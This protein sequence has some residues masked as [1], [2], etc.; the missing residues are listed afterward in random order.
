MLTL[1]LRN[2][3]SDRMT[4]IEC[5]KVDI[6]KED[7]GH[8]VTVFS[9]DKVEEYRVSSGKEYDVG[10]IENSAGSTTQVIRTRA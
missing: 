6:V 1:K 7:G 10:Y 5:D 8:K 3:Q 2:V 9:G 4:I